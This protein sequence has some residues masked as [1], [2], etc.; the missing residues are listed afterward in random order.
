[1]GT[2]CIKDNQNI[3][4]KARKEAA[5]YDERIYSRDGAAELLGVSVSS[6]ADYELGNTKVVPVDKVV[7]MADLYRCPELKNNYCKNECPI[8]RN[9]PMATEAKS[10]EGTALRLLRSLDT[11][12]IGE[13]SKQI[14]DIAA[15]GQVSEE[16]K[17]ELREVVRS[18]DVVMEAM[19]SMRLMAEKIL[20]GTSNEKNTA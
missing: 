3:Y 13:M 19:S 7:L 12:A 9:Y 16:R 18:L 5:S 8:G 10:L 4:F 6:L 1:M 17:P 20:G 11:Q 15:D 14:L 2:D